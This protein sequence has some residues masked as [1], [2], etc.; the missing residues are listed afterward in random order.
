MLTRF[1]RTDSINV[2]LIAV[3]VTWL[4]KG[5]F[6][7]LADRFLHDSAPFEA[8]VEVKIDQLIRAVEKCNR[9]VWV[10][11]GKQPPKEDIEQAQG[12]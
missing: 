12:P 11:T 9:A 8:R 2:A 6:D 5:G 1:R 3:V 10:A 4:G 7:K